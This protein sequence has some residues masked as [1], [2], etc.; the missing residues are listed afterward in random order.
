[1]KKILQIAMTIGLVATIGFMSSCEKQYFVPEPVDPDDTSTT[2]DTVFFATD[3]QPFFDKSC[4]GSC[5]NGGGIPLDLSPGVS[6]DAIINGGYISSPATNS[7]LY[8]KLLP[9]ESMAQYATNAERD[10]TLD[11]I[12]QGAL[13]N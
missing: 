12:E 7:K 3:M 5:H 10:M 9:G 4:V 11:W 13:N 1:M 2:V 6:Y 8:T